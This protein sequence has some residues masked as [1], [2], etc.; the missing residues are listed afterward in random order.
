[1]EN[2]A[3]NEHHCHHPGGTEHQRLAASKFVDTNEEENGSGDY[4]DRPIHTG[5]KERGIS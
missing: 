4:F 5:G 3:E 2:G 1:M